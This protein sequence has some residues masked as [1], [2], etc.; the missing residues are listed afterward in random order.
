MQNTFIQVVLLLLPLMAWVWETIPASTPVNRARWMVYW[1]SWCPTWTYLTAVS[2]R[3]FSQAQATWKWFSWAVTRTQNSVTTRLRE[4]LNSSTMAMMAAEKL[5]HHCCSMSVQPWLLRLWR[6]QRR[7]EV[8]T[9]VECHSW[10]LLSLYSF[11]YSSQDLS[12]D[13]DWF[14]SF[15]ANLRLNFAALCMHIVIV[16]MLLLNCWLNNLVIDSHTLQHFR[17]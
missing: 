11:W 14:W 15:K 13:S 17:D 1:G 10:L 2:W 8:I 5:A 6:R 16:S 4:L 3:V 7:R 9:M 12:T